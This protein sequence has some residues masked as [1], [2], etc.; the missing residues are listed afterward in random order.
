MKTTKSIFVVLLVLATVQM[1]SAYYCPS[2]GRWLSRDPMGELGFEAIRTAS[3]VMPA[4]PETTPSRWV[5][6][7]PNGENFYAFVENNSLN[8]VDFSGLEPGYGNPVSGPNGPVGPS[9]PWG[10]GG[11]FSPVRPQPLSCIESCAW[12]YLIGI[13]PAVGVGIIGTG[14]PVV[15]KP[16]MLGAGDGT[17]IAGQITDAIIKDATFA[18]PKP[19][20]VGWC[21]R[22]AWS[23]SVSRVVSRWVPYVGVVLITYD[24]SGFAGCACGCQ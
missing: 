11:V 9:D 13:Q 20:P 1:A 8:L 6:R 12:K 4:K 24:L 10:P 19:A 18:T 22:I 21:C 14:Q 7:D 17:S 23:K 16:P 5:K 15:P 2:T 3:I